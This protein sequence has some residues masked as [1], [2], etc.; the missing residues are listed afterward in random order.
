MATSY[1]Q[2]ENLTKSYGDRMLF[3]D[4]TFGVYEGD[5]IGIIAKNGTG[6]STLLNI[7]AGNES[8]DSGNVIFRNGLRVGI[9]EQSPRFAPGASIIEA[10]LQEDSPI[11]R[12]ISRYEKD[13]VSGNEN[14]LNESIH[15][16]DSLGGWEY[17]DRVK[18][19]LTQ[20]GITDLTA[21]TEHLSG[22]QAK[23]I[24][25]AN[26]ILR[27]PELIILDEPTNHL[28]IQIIEWLEDYLRK[29]RVTLLMVTHDRYFLD[30]VTNKIIEIDNQQ[31][32][33]YNGNYDYYLR[34]RQE[35][36]EALTA[37]MSKI[38]NTL[39]RETEWMRRQPQARAGKA[40]FRI[41]AYHAL[42]NRKNEL[43]SSRASEGNVDLNV[44]SSYIGSKIFEAEHIN[45][46]FGDK[47]ILRDFNYVFARYERV[48]IIGHNGV[49]K[50][51][52]IKMLQGIVPCDSG[53]WNVGETVKFG[54]YSQDGIQL[55]D[56]K[57]VID[58]ITDIAEE[59]IVN[60]GVHYSPMQF[61]NHFLFSPAD[62]QKYIGTLSGGEKARLHLASVL[63][64]SPNFLIL[65]E[66][67]N[68]LDIVTLGLIEEYLAGFKGCLIVV[69]HDRFFLDSIVDH[70]FVL[71]GDGVVRDFPGSYSDF[72]EWTREREASDNTPTSKGS[73]EKK[74]A[75]RP[76]RERDA[77]KMTFK[78]QREFEQLTKDIDVLTTEK[79]ELDTLFSSGVDVED[80]AGKSARYQ[81]IQTLL[82]EKE[83]RWLELSEKS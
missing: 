20:L 70:L 10:C 2:I 19:L 24:A 15:I 55:D 41:D 59:V 30:R 3:S 71:E 6:K 22:G 9:L 37:E 35:R 34:R 51:T 66:P 53:N 36:I 54:Y 39:R 12:A 81:E 25:I 42:S 64:R 50:S 23:R 26:V 5:K 46:A 11:C 29:S 74:T 77:N 47:V 14:E 8:P 80:I 7:I 69:S 49:G 1:L 43:N 76:K 44:K 16:M 67:T 33:T 65:D 79:K 38:K 58:A 73:P 61:L 78:E 82:D 40:Q 83:M 56:N 68:D 75:N 63:M 28:D 4:V 32:F 72:R 17:E 21:S 18:Q 57:R 27:E 45:K 62:Q 52:F 31:I 60:D 48:G 13:L